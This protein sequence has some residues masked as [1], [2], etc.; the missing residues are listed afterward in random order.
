MAA[1]GAAAGLSELP[2]AARVSCAATVQRLQLLRFPLATSVLFFHSTHPVQALA[3]STPVPAPQLELWAAWLQDFL[4]HGLGGIRM[5]AFFAISGFLFFANCAGTRDWLERKLASRVRSV[6]VPLLAWNALLLPVLLLLQ[7]WPA[8]N[9]FFSG[10]GA[11]SRPV[12]D[13]G[14]WQ[15]VDALL[16]LS[17]YPIVYPL[18]FLRD[19]FLMCLLAPLYLIVPRSVQVVVVVV[20]GL[21][22]FGGAWPYRVPTIEAMFFFF[23]GALAAL[24]AARARAARPTGRRGASA[25]LRCWPRCSGSCP[26]R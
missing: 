11:W 16:G 10:V 17:G 20:L 22:W 6:L 23:A 4:S 26:T 25:C 21:L 24:S 5:P 3:Q 8:S 1:P 9:A 15:V 14:P 19:L 2:S 13:Y 12:A 18:W 7:A